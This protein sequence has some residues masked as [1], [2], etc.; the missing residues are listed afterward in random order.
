M[1][2]Y[3]AFIW[4]LLMQVNK[5]CICVCVRVC[6]HVCVCARARVHGCMLVHTTKILV[7]PVWDP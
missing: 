7:P 3:E 1:W 4:V 6:V 2:V 5:V